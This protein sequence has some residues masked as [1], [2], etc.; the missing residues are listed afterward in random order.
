MFCEHLFRNDKEIELHW[1]IHEE[2]GN[3]IQIEKKLSDE[4]LI[5]VVA[6]SMTNVF[7]VH[8]LGNLI[9]HI[10][11]KYYYYS[12]NDEI[13]RI[14]D[15]TNWIFA[16][17]DQDSIQVRKNKGVDLNQL[18]I[19]LFISN[20]KNTEIIHYDSVVKFGLKAFKDEMIQYVGLAI[21]EYKR[22]EEHQE[23]VYMLRDYISKKE[24][25]IPIIHIVQGKSF[26]FYQ[27][28]GKLLSK[29]ELQT[30]MQ[31][32]PLYIFGLD[33][34]E[35]NLAPLIAMAPKKIKIYGEDPAE[36]KTL[37]VINVFQ[38]K[39]EFESIQKFPFG[40]DWKKENK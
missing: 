33:V 18:L 16:G 8:R 22:E 11:K 34:D 30:I 3:H 25:G 35:L 9:K 6:K 4:H 20:V 29:L 38:E 24:P 1:K 26:A 37:T 15:L 27:E 13:E 17:K 2:W 23:F 7:I 14:H 5:H 12:N 21:D 36:P 28:S 39:A 32:E 10:I 40:L 31:K 19:S